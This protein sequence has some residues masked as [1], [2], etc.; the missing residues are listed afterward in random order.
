[1]GHKEGATNTV[2]SQHWKPETL[3]YVLTTAISAVICFIIGLL[4]GSS[5]H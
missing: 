5:L 2:M 1:M 3:V 4:A